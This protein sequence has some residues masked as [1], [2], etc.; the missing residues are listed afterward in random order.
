MVERIVVR[1]LFAIWLSVFMTGSSIAEDIRT[2]RVEFAPGST[3]ATIQNSIKGYDT[4]DYVLKA[5]AGQVLNVSM[6][7]DNGANYFNIL[8]PGETEVAMFVG[9]TQGNQFEGTLAETG[10]HRVRVYLMRSAARRNEVARYRLEVA[11]SSNDSQSIEVDGQFKT[12][13]EHHFTAHDAIRACE[14]RISQQYG[15]RN[16]AYSDVE[17]AEKGIGHFWIDGKVERYQSRPDAFTCRVVHDEVV[18]Y[19]ILTSNTPRNAIGKSV[20][21]TVL[22]G[23]AK[24][25]SSDQAAVQ[26]YVTYERGNPFRNRQ[27]LKQACRHEIARQLRHS[28]A[29]FERARIVTAHLRGRTLHGDGDIRWFNTDHLVHYSCQFDRRGRV[30]DGQFFYYPAHPTGYRTDYADGFAG[31]PD[32]WRVE[33]VSENDVLYVHRRASLSSRRIGNLPHDA[34]QLRNLGCQWSD[35]DKGTWCEIEYH[36]LRGFAAQLYLRED[37]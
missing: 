21:G 15:Y 16:S 13:D 9:S 29:Q 11:V 22:L 37:S 23:S 17:V 20:L 5:N 34:R 36:G 35:S 32:N 10:D 26:P 12:G 1:C 30:I 8:A 18:S 7:T 6:A 4:V 2:Q 25:G 14:Q 19:R 33:G 28:H 27:H 3:G 24:S 31:G